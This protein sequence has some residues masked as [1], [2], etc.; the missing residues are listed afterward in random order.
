MPRRELVIGKVLVLKFLS[1]SDQLLF[2]DL[3][4]TRR[5]LRRTP[6]YPD[7]LNWQTKQIFTTDEEKSLHCK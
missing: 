5:G 3:L 4:V 1:G 7:G 2:R 6:F